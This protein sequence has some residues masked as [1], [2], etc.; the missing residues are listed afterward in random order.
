MPPKA[1]KGKTASWRKESDADYKNIA[2]EWEPF[3]KKPDSLKYSDAAKTGQAQMDSTKIK[4]HL[5]WIAIV[6]ARQKNCSFIK[7]ELKHIWKAIAEIK[8]VIW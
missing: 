1:C 2:E 6:R 5:K 7:E 3:F 8:G 4:D